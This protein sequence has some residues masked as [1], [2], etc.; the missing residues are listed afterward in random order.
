VDP[1]IK[2]QFLSADLEDVQN[3]R[4]SSKT[5]AF[6]PQIVW[7]NIALF[8]ALHF[9]AL[10]GLYQFMFVASWLTSAWC[11]FCWFVSGVGSLQAPI[12]CGPTRATRQRLP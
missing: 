6:K 9:G 8:V 5:D 1:I 3:L 11:V 2:E 10:I 7:R 12:A 4:D